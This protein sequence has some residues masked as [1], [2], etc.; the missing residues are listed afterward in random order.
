MLFLLR[1]GNSGFD[2]NG[3]RNLNKEDYYSVFEAF[4]KV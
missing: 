4:S 1:T 2:F 3:L